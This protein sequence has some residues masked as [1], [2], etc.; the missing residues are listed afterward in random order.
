MLVSAFSVWIIHDVINIEATLIK[1]LVDVVIFIVNYFIQK[2]YIFKTL[3]VG[4]RKEY[5]Y[6]LQ[7]SGRSPFP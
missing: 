2:K 3:S 1:V 6:G 4:I 7:L 5:I